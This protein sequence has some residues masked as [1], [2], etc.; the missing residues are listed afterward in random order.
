MI[1]RD[2]ELAELST[3]LDTG[4]AVFLSGEA[5]IGKTAIQEAVAGLA[6]DRGVTVLRCAGVLDDLPVDFADLHELLLPVLDR[7]V[8]LPAHH[9]NAVRAAFGE[10]GEPVDAAR[11]KPAVLALLGLAPVAVLVDDWQ[12]LDP[13][14]RDV[15]SFV[16][17]GLSDGPVFLAATLRA[18]AGVTVP[19]RRRRRELRPLTDGAA[20]ALLDT[21][22]VTA[23]RAALLA[24]AGG[25]PL[26][27]IE[28][29]G[30]ARM[31]ERLEWSFLRETH[32]HQPG[33]RTLLLCAAADAGLTVAEL[34]GAGAELGFD[35]TDL[36]AVEQAGLLTAGRDRL[37]FRHPL[38][39]SAAY[40]GATLADRLAAHRALA[41]ASTDPDR[42][43]WHRAAGTAGADDEA[44]A[45]LAGV[46]RR[47]AGRGAPRDAVTAMRRAAELSTFPGRRAGYL[48][49][50]AEVARQAGLGALC[51]QLVEQARSAGP[52]PDA[53]IRLAQTEAGN[54][55]ACGQGSRSALG[56]LVLVHEAARAHPGRP[57]EPLRLL[58]AVAGLSFHFPQLAVVR[59][60]AVAELRRLPL[61]PADPVR[62][63]ALALLDPVGQAAGVRP[64]LAEM[65]PLVAEDSKLLL[66]YGWAASVLHDLPHAVAGHEAALAHLRRRG[67]CGDEARELAFLA[68]VRVVTGDLGRARSD[69]LTAIRMSAALGMPMAEAE[70][71]AALALVHAWSGDTDA[72][73]AAI[74]L[75]RERTV[76]PWRST[77]ARLSW[78]AGLS[79]LGGRRYREAWTALRGT[80]ADPT[81]AAWAIADIADAA[82]LS[83]KT[84]VTLTTGT[85]PAVNAKT[86][87]ARELL[88]QVPPTD[89]GHLGAVTRRAHAL[90]A[91]TPEDAAR[92]FEASLECAE[93][94][95]SPLELAR[96]RLAY[97]RWLRRT[98]QVARSR[99]ELTAALTA[100]TAAG[101]RAWA[102]QAAD[103]LRAA[104][105]H[106]AGPL[107]EPHPADG[108]RPAA[109]AATGG[110]VTAL[111]TAQERRV[112]E[113]AATGL[114]NKEIAN[115][116]YLSHR[117]VGSH[118]HRL[119]H[120]LGLTYRTQLP[121]ALARPRAERSPERATA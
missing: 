53:L 47:A 115:R 30:G 70:A 112:A 33:S 52:A 31:T 27:L 118:M 74:D 78:A 101:A 9:R 71:Q 44:A 49:E 83:A 117:T 5:G 21:L 34:M 23:S 93:R 43:A 120:K 90:L 92:H 41:R 35:D 6:R 94:A 73:S 67:R 10:T 25:N 86:D 42:A 95:G 11:L 85:D 96:T 102:G 46:G 50:A 16:A 121:D 7:V 69:A 14:T 20:N 82:A 48:A 106:T 111:L 12:W 65:L 15:L 75:G 55:S 2:E 59:E 84:D 37:V 103:E 57:E 81:T 24:R 60:A 105:H 107:I 66:T 116:L 119:L 61:D 88:A 87:A 58:W 19:A 51:A 91:T 89:S 64:R 29:A 26:A 80:A 8:G 63:V 32:T 110:A 76:T 62:A 113:L 18:S 99:A 38:V 13:S 22:P 45:D 28:L 108:D 109:P 98:R 39:R 77:V 17:A 3:L 54:S 1:G 79:A 72:V 4:G 97:G 68:T 56:L 100:F 40:D 104:G 36:A 114:T